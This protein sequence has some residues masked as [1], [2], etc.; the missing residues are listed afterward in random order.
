MNL[1]TLLRMVCGS[2]MS[3][4]RVLDVLMNVHGINAHIES[5]RVINYQTCQTSD[6]YALCL[7]VTEY[8][9]TDDVIVQETQ[10]WYGTFQ[11]GF[12]TFHT[13]VLS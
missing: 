5:Q 13:F 9:L 7:P 12:T 8:V 2:D 1:L 6:G 11:E 3:I 4:D 10:G